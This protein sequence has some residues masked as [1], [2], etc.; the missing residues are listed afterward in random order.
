MD[1]QHPRD[2]Y[3]IKFLLDNEGITEQIRKGFL[4]YLI[5]HDRPIH[6]LLNPV[7]KEF[8]IVYDSE[9]QG[10]TSDE[11]SYDDLVQARSMLVDIIKK[12][13]TK[14]EKNFL[15]SLKKGEPNW[16]LLGI[17]GA[18]RLPA[19]QWKLI[20]IRKMGEEKRSEFLKKL[21]DSLAV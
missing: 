20:N 21:K 9:F 10:M 11:V 17:D 2:L 15:V 16:N 13:L 1:R 18:D 4:V 8:K 14:D 6:E 7:L 3:D 12:I 5:S 19:V